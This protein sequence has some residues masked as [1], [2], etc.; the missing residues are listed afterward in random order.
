MQMQYMQIYYQQPYMA[1]QEKKEEQGSGKVEEGLINS[2]RKVS[3]SGSDGSDI[4]DFRSL[5][6]NNSET[7]NTFVFLL[8]NAW[9][10]LYNPG[11]VSEFKS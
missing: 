5:D 7:E 6:W 4:N 8:E 1:V 2:N 9:E 3:S 11:E 10:G